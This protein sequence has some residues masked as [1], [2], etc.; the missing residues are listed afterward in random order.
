MSGG[1][2]IGSRVIT[3]FPHRFSGA[4]YIVGAD[5]WTRAEK[6]LKPAIVANRYVFITGSEDFNRYE[7]DRVFGMYQSAGAEHS[8]RMSLSGFRHEYPGA[9]ILHQALEYLDAR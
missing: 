8:R 7:M 5:F 9:E 4:I 3:M 1:G 2:R 6:P